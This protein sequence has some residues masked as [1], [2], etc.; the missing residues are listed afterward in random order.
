MPVKVYT[1]QIAI[2]KKLGLHCDPRYLDI[3]VKSGDKT[4]APTWDMVMGFKQGKITETEYIRLYLE[5]MRKS[6][7]ENRQ[8]WEEI[9]GMTDVVLACYCK[10]EDFCHRHILRH[11][12]CK[13]GAEP[14]Q[15]LGVPEI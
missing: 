14:M 8:R 10:T 15:E 4:F 9:F 1:V 13:L 2:A 6:F 11:I 3:T 12:F 5:S 7:K